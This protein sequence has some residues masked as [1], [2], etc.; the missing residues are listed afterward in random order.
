MNKYGAILSFM[1]ILLSEVIS[2]QDSD[3]QYRK[4][5]KEVI[6]LLEK[7]YHITIKYSEAQVE[8]KWLDYADWRFRTD[9]D[10]TLRNVLAPLDMKVNKEGDG[11]YKLK[12]YEYYRWE[13]KEGWDYLDQLATQYHDQKSWEL[14]KDSIKAELYRAVRL[15][16]MPERPRSKPILTPKRIFEGYTVQNFALEILPGVFVNGS[17]YAP[18]K[19]K[20]KIPVVLSPDGHWADHRYR[21]DAQVRCA[22]TAKMGAIAISYD[23]FAWGESLLQFDFEDHRKSLAL[24]IQTLGGIRILDYVLENRQVDATRVGICGGSG[25]GSHTVLMTALDDRITL[26]IPVVSLSSYFYG[27]CPCESGMPIHACGGGTNN[28]EL[29][30]MAAPRPQ[31]VV[32]DGK[33]WT[34]HMPQHDYPYLQKIYGYYG[35]EANVQNVHLP[36]DGHD[37]GYSKRKPVYDFLSEHF[38]LQTM[39]LKGADGEYDESGC[40]IEEKTALYTFGAQGENLPAHAIHGFKNLEKLFQ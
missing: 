9:V 12:E 37:F 28:V 8:G 11:K 21:K 31:L 10:Q 20:G 16:P 1:L 26:S 36:E 18:A 14:R 19:Y 23:L 29:A 34:A 15:S 24:T 22:M 25:G 13:V 7:R 6:E 2:A 33:D 39:G 38:R 5:L 32:S 4:P 27:G 17:I 30:A 40:T 3:H 35:V